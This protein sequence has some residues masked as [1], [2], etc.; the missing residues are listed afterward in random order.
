MILQLVVV[1]K[2]RFR[3]DAHDTGYRDLNVVVAFQG[4]LCEIQVTYFLS[5]SIVVHYAY[6]NRSSVFYLLLADPLG[7]PLQAEEIPAPNL[8]ALPVVWVSGKT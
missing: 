3:G 1:V 4:F 2:N 6:C 7:S 5:Y 8:H